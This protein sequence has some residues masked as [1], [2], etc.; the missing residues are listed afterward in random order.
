MKHIAILASSERGISLGKKLQYA[1]GQAK[2]ESEIAIF[3]VRPASDVEQIP[4]TKEFLKNGFRAFDAFIF[5]GALGICVRSIA[6]MLQ[7]KYTDPA[8]INCD[9]DGQFVQS[10]LSG[11][12]GGANL[13]TREVASMLGAAPVITTS[14]DVQGLWSL[15]TLGRRLGWTIEIHGNEAL[16]TMNNFIARFIE[17]KPCALLIETRDTETRRLIQTKPDFVDV[18]YSLESIHFSAYHLLL[19]VTPKRHAA[20]I[21]ALFYRPKVLSV[22]LGCEKNI[23]ASRFVASFFEHFAETGYAAASIH[24]IGSASLKSAEPAFLKLAETLGVPFRTFSAEALNKVASVPNP[25]ERVFE[26]VGLYSVSEAAAALLS[27]NEAWLVEKQKCSL[28]GVENGQPKHY[29]FA[30]SQRANTA[31]TGHIAIVG[32]GPGDPELI[33]LKGKSYLQ[34]ADLVLYAGSLVPEELTYYARSGALVKSS[35]DLSLEAQFSLMK[36]FY[37]RGEFVVRLHTGDPSIYGAIQE[38]MQY[39]DA[40]GM[41][42]EI[43]PGV[44][45]FQAAAAA[46]KSEFTIPERVQ[47]II[48]TRGEGRTPVPE[49]ERLSELARSQSTLCIYLSATLAHKVQSELLEHYPPETPVAVCYKLTWKDQRIWNGKL[50]NLAELVQ[51]SGKTRTVLLVVGEA[52]LARSE[53]SKLYDPTFAHGFREATK[54]SEA[55]T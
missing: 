24:S 38:Q 36:E 22:G 41:S 31:R 37:D 10:V 4:S 5:I 23:D 8:V 16:K 14:S 35:A 21:P 2:P 18:F 19:A 29:T 1:L 15:D 40:H 43:V 51:E 17:R 46:L 32:A 9:D 30:V 12:I 27:E 42:Y 55:A 39:F 11:H 28:A 44:S 47:T 13:L 20:P 25:S 33:T 52:I 53:R 54:P 7:S 6:P 26:K 48:L 45:S 49:K 3:S 34:E 50:K